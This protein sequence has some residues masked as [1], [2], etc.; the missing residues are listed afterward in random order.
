MRIKA[1]MKFTLIELLVVIAIIAILASMLLPALNK[2]RES[3]RKIQCLNNLKQI[4]MA[5]AQYAG[6]NN[7][8]IWHTAYSVAGYDN[9]VQ[10]LYGG[11]IYPQQKYISNKNLFCCPSS[12]VAT[13]TGCYNT[14]GMYKATRDGEYA[15]KGFNF[16]ARTSAGTLSDVFLF[17]NLERMA[18]PSRFVMLA[19]TMGT[20]PASA[21]EYLKPTW[22]LSTTLHTDGSYAH[23]RH[24][25]FANCGFSDGH[26]GSLDPLAMRATA[27]AIH[28]STDSNYNI[29]NIP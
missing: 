23:L 18:N 29:I 3:A 6:D 24:N 22:Q 9:W 8:W 14:Y 4:G 26:A 2:G 7:A 12:N 17:Y 5:Q 25:K 13:F 10:C 1:V 20:N 28:Y 21:T 11:G 19:D 15:A 16:T 27:T